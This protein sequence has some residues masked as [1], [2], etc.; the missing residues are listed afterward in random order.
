MPAKE[1]LDIGA[2]ALAFVSLIAVGLDLTAGDFRRLRLRPGVVA[3]GVFAPLVALPVIAVALVR[4]FEPDAFVQAGLLLVAACPI[5]GISN[6]YSYLA[7]ASVALSV[8]LTA[9][10]CLVAVAAIPA[11]TAA[12]EWALQAPVRT[13]APIALLVMQLALV[14]VL[15]VGLGIA[16]RRRWPA[17]AQARRGAFQRLAFVLLGLLLLLVVIAERGRIAATFGE[18]V[19]I[20]SVFVTLSFAAGWLAGLAVRAGQAD[21][22]TLGAEFATRNVAVATMIAV[23]LL[24]HTEFAAFGSVYFLTE[25]P[26]MLAAVAIRRRGLRRAGP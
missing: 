11:L 2:P 12:F 6:L 25:L 17:W 8:A 26:I 13:D 7:R 14:V 22:F 1:I 20:A 23:T 10:S 21:R 3:I 18:V 9:A 4:W 19:L 24:G 16:A 15:P 5:G